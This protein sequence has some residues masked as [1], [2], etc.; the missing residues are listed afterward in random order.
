MPGS[1]FR[2][3]ESHQLAVLEGAC[4]ECSNCEVYCPEQGAPFVVK[5]RLFLTRA[6]LDANPSL[7]GFSR[8]GTRLHC[9]IGG[10]RLTLD[11]DAGTRTGMLTGEGLHLAIAWDSLEVTGGTLDPDAPS[12]DT[13]DL[14]RMKVVWD[15]IFMGTGPNPVNP[16]PAVRR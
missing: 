10:R 13:A 4:N 7:D 11:V 5:E 8:D 3:A 15:G 1:G 12:F 2:V 9:R 14:W 16:D 6:D